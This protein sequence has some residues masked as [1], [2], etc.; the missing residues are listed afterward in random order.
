MNFEEYCQEVMN[1]A[2]QYIDEEYKNYDREYDIVSDL[3]L[4]VTGSD[5]GSYYCNSYKAQEALKDVIFDE[6]FLEKLDEYNYTDSFF[7]DLKDMKYELADITVRCV[8][9]WEKEYDIRNYA[10]EK[11]I[12]G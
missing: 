2:T 7:K 12:N 6:Y 4:R 10:K 9:F 11:M 5:N 8:A 3:F 1:D